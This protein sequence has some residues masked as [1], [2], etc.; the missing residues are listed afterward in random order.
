VHF[1]E[2]MVMRI[3]YPLD[4]KS[5]GKPVGGAARFFVES[6]IIISYRKKNVIKLRLAFYFLK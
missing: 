2:V 1:S 6:K 3:S 5:S 4:R